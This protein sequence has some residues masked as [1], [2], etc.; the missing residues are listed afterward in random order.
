MSAGVGQGFTDYGSMDRISCLVT[1]DGVAPAA[2]N[3]VL[4][5]VKGQ[6]KTHGANHK[7]GAKWHKAFFG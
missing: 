5:A 2:S 7:K 1:E 4:T 3:A 6:L